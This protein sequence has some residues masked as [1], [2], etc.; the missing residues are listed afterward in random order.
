MAAPFDSTESWIC[1]NMLVCL[2][3]WVSLLLGASCMSLFPS[4]QAELHPIVRT[5]AAMVPLSGLS[6]VGIV[7]MVRRREQR[8]RS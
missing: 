1:V 7:L 8:A 2:L 3:S 6:S 4:L 5:A